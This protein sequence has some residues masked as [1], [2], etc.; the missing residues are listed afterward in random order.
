MG[1]AQVDTA[2]AQSCCPEYGCDCRCPG[3][4]CPTPDPCEHDDGNPICHDGFQP[5]SD[6]QWF[7]QVTPP[8]FY[9]SVRSGMPLTL[10]AIGLICGALFV[11]KIVDRWDKEA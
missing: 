3:R 11:R 7:W 4:V 10:V 8:W 2:S 9:G 5:V 6:C 1:V